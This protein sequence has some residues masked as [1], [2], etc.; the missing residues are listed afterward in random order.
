MAV[1]TTL[2]YNKLRL[3]RIYSIFRIAYLENFA[4]TYEGSQE[5]DSEHQ[6]KDKC[7]CNINVSTR[8]DVSTSSHL[9]SNIMLWVFGKSFFILNGEFWKV[10]KSDVLYLIPVSLGL[11]KK[12]IYLPLYSGKSRTCFLEPSTTSFFLTHYQKWIQE[13]M[14]IK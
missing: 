1:W 13:A 12:R 5:E 2:H 11:D 6:S 9:V 8:R 7:P 3:I 4:F 14:N 10:L